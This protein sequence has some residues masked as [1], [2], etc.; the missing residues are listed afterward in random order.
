MPP[1]PN[2]TAPPLGWTP[3][4]RHVELYLVAGGVNATLTPAA[5]QGVRLLAQHI[6]PGRDRVPLTPGGWL[7]TYLHGEPDPEGTPVTGP[8]GKEWMVKYPT[9]AKM[10]AATKQAATAALT[11]FERAVLASPIGDWRAVAH[12]AAAVDWFVAAETFKTT[13]HTYHSA[14]FIHALGGAD[15]AL[16]FG[17]VWATTQGFGTCCGYPVDGYQR[18]GASTGAR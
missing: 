5:Y 15:P 13:K 10:D 8:D 12:E 11:A 1:L 14:S 9:R 17:P 16:R 7:A 4:T 2:A 6:E 3:L 18:G